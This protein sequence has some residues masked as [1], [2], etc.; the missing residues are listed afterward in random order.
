MQI[1]LTVPAY[2]ASGTRRKNEESCAGTPFSRKRNAAKIIRQFAFYN[3]RSETYT[4]Y[5][6]FLAYPPAMA[7]FFRRKAAA[8]VSDPFSKV[9]TTTAIS[10]KI[11]LS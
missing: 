5:D 4:G 8:S 1:R 9:Y 10:G 11:Y 3:N 2:T 6:S 7:A